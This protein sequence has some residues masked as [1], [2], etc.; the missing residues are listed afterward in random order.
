MLFVDYLKSECQ[1][2]TSSDKLVTELFKL[3]INHL[4]QTTINLGRQSQQ[5]LS[6]QARVLLQQARISTLV[7]GCN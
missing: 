6:Q 3:Q 5:L 2:T 1:E 4:I 7:R